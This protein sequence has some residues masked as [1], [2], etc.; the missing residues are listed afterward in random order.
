M[1]ANS[2]E[3]VEA[4]ELHRAQMGIV[5]KPVSAEEIIRAALCDDRLVLAGE[6]AHDPE[7]PATVWL[8][9]E[10]GSGV[11]YYTDLFFSQRAIQPAHRVEIVGNASICA[12][13]AA[14]VGT[15]LVS[16]GVVPAGVPTAELGMDFSRR[17]SGVTPRSGLTG[18]QRGMCKVIASLFAV[19]PHS[20]S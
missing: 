12:C 20:G 3:I 16:Q 2:D 8:L 13:L 6:H 1:T 18:A 9:R 19:E 17:F 14:G 5:E 4:V 11:C 10:H 15:S 7:N